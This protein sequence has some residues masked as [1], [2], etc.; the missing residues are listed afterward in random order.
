MASSGDNI[1]GYILEEM[2]NHAAVFKTDH[3]TLMLFVECI[4]KGVYKGMQELDD[5]AGT[6]PSTGHM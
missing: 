5:K 4:A 3:P 1:K 2:A 6:P